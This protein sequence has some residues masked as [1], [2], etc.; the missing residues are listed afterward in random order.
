[1]KT[2]LTRY[3]LVRVPGRWG[4]ARIWITDDGCITT[5][6]DYGNFGYWFGAPG[7]EF[8]KFLIGVCEWDYLVRKFTESDKSICNPDAS[9][10]KI[11]RHILEYRRDGHLD[12]DSAREEWDLLHQNRDM[13]PLEQTHW[14]EGT[15]LGDAAELF[16]YEKEGYQAAK[17]FA[18]H[19]WPLFVGQL[20][21]ELAGEALIQGQREASRQAADF[22]GA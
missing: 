7:C 1:M 15:K 2:P 17:A 14:Y 3:Y 6:S 18:E 11:K 10:K 21:E 22:E 4:W 12:R 16:T 13:G 20:K 9:F 19:I 5:I 8:R